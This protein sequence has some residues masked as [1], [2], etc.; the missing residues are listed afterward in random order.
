LLQLV[1]W[2]HLLKALLCGLS[3]YVIYTWPLRSLGRNLQARS[4]QLAAVIL[5]L[6][7]FAAVGLLMVEDNHR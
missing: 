6:L 4:A 1:P 2:L 5:T 7:V 3:T